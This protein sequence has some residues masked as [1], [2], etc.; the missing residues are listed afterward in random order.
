MHIRGAWKNHTEFQ[1][2][3]QDEVLKEVIKRAEKVIAEKKLPVV[4][5]DLDSTL[6]DVSKRSFEILR[7]W[8]S[9]SETRNFIETR[10][11]LEGLLPTDMRYSL[12]D[13]W[14][15]KKVP[16]QDAPYD[17]HLKH[18]KQFWRHRFFGNDYLIHDEPTPGAVAFVKQLHA[19]GAKI[20]YLTGRDVPQMAF[21]TFDQLKAHGLPVET[22]RTRLI[23][24]PKRHIDDL[25]FKTGAAKTIMTFGAVIATFENEPKNLVAMAA[26]FG[27]ETMNVFI[28]TVS[29]DH[30]APA[31]KGI[32]RI[33]DFH[34]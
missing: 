4:V 33:G 29:S 25:E 14:E 28:D 7:E 18:A 20:V 23:L 19:M 10:T 26:V 30:P 1:P 11:K 3:G 9:H 21:G 27:P 32:Y 16:H 6:F 17:H 13:V 8:L 5:F 24:K 2:Q 31:G 15:I 34:F 12:E 22:E